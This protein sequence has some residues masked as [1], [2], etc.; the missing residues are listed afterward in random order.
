MSDNDTIT[1]KQLIFIIIGSQIAIGLFSL[2]RVVSSAAG[3]D[4]WLAVLLGALV[5]F[6]TL[7]VIERLGRRMPDAGFVGMNHML[8][9]RWLGSGMVFLFIIYVVFFQAVVVRL[10]SELTSIFLLPRTPLSVIVLLV[11]LGAVYVII[12]GSRVIARVNEILFWILLPLLFFLLAP[13]VN[14]DYTNLLPVGE[15]GLARIAQG[16]FTSSYY[17][18]GIEVLL[19]FYFLVGRKEEVIKAGIL[20]LGYSTI[21]Y[22]LIT[23]ACLMVWGIEIM[24]FINW[25]GLSI[26]KTIRFEVLERPELFIL[27]VWMG[28]GVRPTMNMGFSASYS[29][30]EI[31]GIDRSKYFHLVVLCLALLIYIIA[32]LPSNIISAF[33]W[34]EYAGYSFWLAGVFYP[35]I[36]LLTAI[37][38]GKET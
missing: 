25:P 20:G 33:K 18:A 3:Q 21:A 24:Q 13:M 27:A 19:V 32:L 28:L 36:M 30:S 2:P 11:I 1:S 4:A 16:A 17:Y 35:L 5:P 12:K 9:G 10:F 31:I 29:L 14:A 26:L 7:F 8:F 15:A 37:I 6:F 34:A 23:L 22:L 38:R